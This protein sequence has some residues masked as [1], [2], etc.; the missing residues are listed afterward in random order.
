MI[1]L[2]KEELDLIRE[3][4]CCIKDTTKDYLEEKDELLYQK[5]KELLM[6]KPEPNPEPLAR[7]MTF[8]DH[9]AGLAMQGILAG[10][11]EYNIDSYMIVAGAYSIASAML[12]HRNSIMEARNGNP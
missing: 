5:I 10:D 1:D 4:Y 8:R 2:S 12:K 9:F 7:E 3:W 11:N 6:E